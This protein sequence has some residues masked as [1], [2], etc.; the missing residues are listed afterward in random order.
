[1]S[2]SAPLGAQPERAA[3][4]SWLRRHYGRV[5]LAQLALTFSVLLIDAWSALGRSPRAERLER[6]K[7]SPQYGDGAFVNPIPMNEDMGRALQ[8]W[9][10]GPSG[11]QL[12][13]KEAPP[14]VKLTKEA[15]ISPPDG[16]LRVTWFGH[17]SVLIE[18]D[19]VRILA[20]PV[21]GRRASPSS[22][23]GPERF[24]EP[25]LPLAELPPLD[26]ILISHDHYDHLDLPS[27]QELVT[28]TQAPFF[29]PLGL[30][31]HLQYWGVNPERIRELDW[32]QEARVGDVKLACTPARHFSGRSLTDRNATL[33]SSWS[34]VG[35]TRR[36]F[37]SGDTGMFSGFSEIGRRYG[38]FDVTLLESGAYDDAW[39]DV[40]L[41]PEQAVEAHLALRGTHLMPIHW[42]TFN[43]ALHSWT[44]PGERLRVAA[45]AAGVSLVTPAPGGSLELGKPLP[46]AVWWPSVPWRSATEHPVRSSAVG[47]WGLR[48]V[49]GGVGAP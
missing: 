24:F 5:I 33:W 26:A 40:H 22:F 31:E 15:L 13:P 43:L 41:G 32:W 9:L 16:Q 23:F 20:D 21:W 1:M 8:K 18:V 14:V 4:K 36:V 42:G 7:A 12:T 35:P 28:L 11:Q 2:P 27:I 44:E 25:P 49:L 10:F 30:G 6:A 47:E 29:V 45:A 34:V 37:F 48:G 46:T 39:A 17:S 3:P 38:P 19:G